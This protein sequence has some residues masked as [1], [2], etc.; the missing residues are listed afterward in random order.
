MKKIS[1][2]LPIVVLTFIIS[3]VSAN[4]LENLTT[5]ID[6]ATITTQ[7]KS[8]LLKDQLLNSAGY[9]ALNVHVE[10]VNSVVL[11]TGQVGNAEQKKKVVETAKSVNGVKGVFDKLTIQ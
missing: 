3:N 11:L 10:T 8:T 5:D 6:D 9:N 7:V 2:L 4:A 1:L